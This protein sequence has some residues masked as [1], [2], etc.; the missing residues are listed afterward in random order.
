MYPGAVDAAHS[1]EL[2]RA[3]LFGSVGAG[4]GEEILLF[5]IPI[6]LARRAGWSTP[7]TIA[8]VTVLRLAIHTYYG[9]GSAFVLLWIPAGYALYR[10]AGAIWPLIAAHTIYDGVA[11]SID[12]W[13]AAGHVLTVMNLACALLGAVVMF[14]GYNRYWRNRQAARKALPA[15]A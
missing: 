15:V 1:S 8:L 13:P 5:A 14:V 6:A 4:I 7:S 11:F 2:A 12:S 9:W 10:A 3:F